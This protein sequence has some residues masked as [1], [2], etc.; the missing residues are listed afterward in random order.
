MAC[1]MAGRSWWHA[2]A[3]LGPIPSNVP[4][5]FTREVHNGQAEAWVGRNGYGGRP[6][7][8]GMAW[9]VSIT[10]R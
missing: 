1:R 9:S 6:W 3:L 7:Q 5:G 8:A 10:G 4:V 2:K